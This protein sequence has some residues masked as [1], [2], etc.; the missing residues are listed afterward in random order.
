MYNENRYNKR[1]IAIVNE[2]TW[3]CKWVHAKANKQKKFHRIESNWI[4]SKLSSNRIE[5]FSSLPN[6]PALVTNMKY[7]WSAVLSS[8]QWSMSMFITA[9]TRSKSVNPAGTGETRPPKKNEMSNG[10]LIR[11][12]LKYGAFQLASNYMN[13]FTLVFYCVQGWLD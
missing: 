1:I 4:E 7:R 3:W 8:D 12:A 11:H 9:V 2:A 13:I 5:S 10:M 6:R